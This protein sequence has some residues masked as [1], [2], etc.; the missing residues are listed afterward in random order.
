MACIV[1]VDLWAE[2]RTH[3]F[4]PA[5]LLIIDGRTMKELVYGSSLSEETLES[6]KTLRAVH[7]SHAIDPSS[8]S[9]T[10]VW[11]YVIFASQSKIPPII[12]NRNS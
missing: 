3:L 2:E 4:F 12:P 8:K 6:L 10:N 5:V 11:W 1:I 7:K 9:P